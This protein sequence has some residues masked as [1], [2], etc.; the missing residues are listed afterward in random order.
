MYS[1]SEASTRK[2]TEPVELASKSNWPELWREWSAYYIS[3]DKENRRQLE[4]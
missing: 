3:R 4:G 2:P 1:S